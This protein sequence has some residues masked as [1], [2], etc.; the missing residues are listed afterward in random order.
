[1]G[2]KPPPLK[3]VVSGSDGV[4]GRV[5]PNWLEPNVAPVTLKRLR[6]RNELK[7][8]GVATEATDPRQR[9]RGPVVE[10]AKLD[11]RGF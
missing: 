6:A 1:M 7:A 5:E 8:G 9:S 10:G 4:T 3:G 2:Q 11:R